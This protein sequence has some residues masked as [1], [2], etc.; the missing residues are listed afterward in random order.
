MFGKVFGCIGVTRG[1]NITVDVPPVGCDL[2]KLCCDA[3]LW[4][5]QLAAI[6]LMREG[7]THHS[8]QL[9]AGDNRIQD[10]RAGILEFDSA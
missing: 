5:V 7:A 1:A 10:N 2:K 6:H 3:F 8:S 9:T 4:F